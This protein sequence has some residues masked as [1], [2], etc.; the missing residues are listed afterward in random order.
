MK[1]NREKADLNED[2]VQWL[3]AGREAE[4]SLMDFE[5]EED[6]RELWEAH[7]DDVIARWVE[8]YPCTRPARWWEFSAPRW[9][10]RF[11][12]CFWDG[13]L[14]DPRQR[15]GGTGTP[16]FEVLNYVPAFRFGLPLSWITDGDVQ[17]YGPDFRGKAIDRADP[18]L[19]ESQA[20]Y[21]RRHGILTPAE[22]KYLEKHP[23]VL[24]AEVVTK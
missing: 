20:A 16:T 18:P 1:K 7:C 24:D 17:Y 8:S 3:F 10:R 11:P 12:G 15:I 14:P 9:S 5:E 2:Q 23:E 4:F 22:V 19:Y 13:K 21:L 6:R